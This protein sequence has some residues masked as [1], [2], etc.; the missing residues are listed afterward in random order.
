L[1]GIRLTLCDD[2]SEVGGGSL[3]LEKMA[4]CIL[5]ITVDSYSP[6]Q[7]MAAL[8][9]LSTPIIGRI[10]DDEV[11]LDSRTL[12]DDELSLV[13]DLFEELIKSR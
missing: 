13:A 2:Y 3:P 4:S 8:R 10:Q 9:G 5:K 12:F 11:I 1:E 7:L 6:N